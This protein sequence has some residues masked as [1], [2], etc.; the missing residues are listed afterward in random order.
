[1]QPETKFK[2]KVQTVLKK[3]P[4]VWVVKI[5]Q[6]A[7]RG[8][9]DMLI[10]YKGNFLAWELKVPPNKLKARSLQAHNLESIRNAGGIARVVTPCTLS[11]AIEEMLCLSQ[12]SSKKSSTKKK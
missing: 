3:I 10:C 7:L 1:M 6:L 8:I 2:I 9:P 5:Q 12:N 4:E 11:E